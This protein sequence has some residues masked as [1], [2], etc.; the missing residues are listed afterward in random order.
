M[1]RVSPD[2]YPDP[3]NEGFLRYW[4]GQAWTA[5]RRAVSTKHASPGAS[6]ESKVPLFGARAYAKR[7]ADELAEALVENR[8]LREQLEQIGGLGIGD[9][10]R[11][12]AQLE[13][14][15]AEHQAVRD[16]LVEQVV[17]MREQHLLQEIGIYEYRHPLSDS[18]A[19]RDELRRLQGEIKALARRDGGAIEAPKAWVVEGSVT[20]GRRMIREYSKLMLRAYNAEAEN[21][22]RSLKPYRLR[23]TLDR[24]DR[25]ADTL[26]RF[27][28]TMQLRIA[29]EYHRL[30]RRELELTAD[31]LELLARQKEA[32]RDERERLREERRAQEE[33]AREQS[34][35]EQQQ[36]RDRQALSGLE[37]AGNAETDAANELR[38]RLA[39]RDRAIASIQARVDDV[40]AG[41]VYVI[42][43]IGAF[44]P[45]VVQIGLTRRFHPYERISELSNA[46]VPFKYD[47][48]ALFFDKDAAGIEAE[49]HRRLEDKRI[50]KVNRRREFFR[51]TPTE[52]REHLREVTDELLEFTE[53]PEADQY[54]QS[55]NAQQGT[56]RPQSGAKTRNPSPPITLT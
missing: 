47:V 45:D 37:A 55:R 25:L 8:W 31:H 42:S 14:Q 1:S 5:D 10:Q 22:V 48:H 38:E 24:L 53:T 36:E 29:P 26:E 20:D 40:R 11:L 43:N 50:N 4:D 28:A 44:G 34:K 9:L 30:R 52:V 16:D 32:E 18:V 51:V 6:D 33:L 19:Y 27:G 41:Y 23:K 35:L 3:Q 21:L 2:W 39:E 54:R 7:Q 49:L 56:A 12:Q 46:S 13:A 15:I 17:D